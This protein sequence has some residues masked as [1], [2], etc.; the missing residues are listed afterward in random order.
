LRVHH[1]PDDLQRTVRLLRVDRAGD[2]LHRIADP[3][4]LAEPLRLLT[5]AGLSAGNQL[6]IGRGEHSGS[7]PPL[8]SSLPENE[9]AESGSLR[10]RN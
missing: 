1:R 5:S 2:H 6:S 3:L 7:A 8:L 4:R 10:R 9:S